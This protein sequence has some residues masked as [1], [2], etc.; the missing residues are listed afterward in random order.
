[1]RAAVNGPIDDRCEIH[2]RGRGLFRIEEQ[3]HGSRLADSIGR[4]LQ[5]TALGKDVR[6]VDS[7]TKKREQ[8]D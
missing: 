8:E 2:F 7:E 5:L 1:L 4:H 6:V 3:I